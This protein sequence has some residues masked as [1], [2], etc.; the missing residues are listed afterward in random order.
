[1]R[2][3][4]PRNPTHRTWPHQNVPKTE[5]IR[6]YFRCCRARSHAIPIA[7][8]RPAPPDLPPRPADQRLKIG[9]E[10]TLSVFGVADIFQNL[11]CRVDAAPLWHQSQNRR[12]RFIVLLDDTINYPRHDRIVRTKETISSLTQPCRD[13]GRYL[14][15]HDDS[16][17][18]FHG[19]GT[20]AFRC[21]VRHW[22]TPRRGGVR[23]ASKMIAVQLELRTI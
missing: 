9:T 19:L 3:Q 22:K 5:V 13:T 18:A 6:A 11:H 12:L 7:T 14:Y 20:V 17:C 10:S 23:I 16:F 2:C 15:P 21:R 8:G 4:N 1:M